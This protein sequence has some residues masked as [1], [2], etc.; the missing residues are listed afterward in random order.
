MIAMFTFFW[1]QRRGSETD[2]MFTHSMIERQSCELLPRIW[3][4]SKAI[5]IVLTSGLLSFVA[6]FLYLKKYFHS[7]ILCTKNHIRF[8]RTCFRT[9][10]IYRLHVTNTDHDGES[11]ALVPYLLWFW[12]MCAPILLLQ[13]NQTIWFTRTFSHTYN[14]SRRWPIWSD[15]ESIVLIS[16]SFWLFAFFD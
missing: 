14:P 15:G 8:K 7:I 4:S 6:R 9:T 16:G 3:F 10:T 5:S 1:Q 11:I 2:A 13:K 12:K